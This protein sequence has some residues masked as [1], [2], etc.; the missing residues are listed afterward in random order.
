MVSSLITSVRGTLE[1]V[2]PDWADVSVG[3]FTLRLS[4]PTSAAERLGSIGDQVRLVT[5]LQVREDSLTL[6]G[7]LTEEDR[8]TFDALIGVNG[9]G[10][11]VALSVLSRFTPA[12]LAAAV[13]SGDTD[14]FAGVSGVGKK[15]ASRIVL[16]LKGKLQGDWAVPAEAIGHAEVIEALTALGYSISEARDAAMTLTPDDPA[17]LEERLRLILQRMGSL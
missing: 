1:S 4:I 15:T 13:G 3:G 12:S 10:P 17:P 11:R 6:F 16:E 14:A 8:L 9:V 2:G 5:S 7:F